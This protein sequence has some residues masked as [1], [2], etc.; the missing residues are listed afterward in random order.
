M[1]TRVL[2]TRDTSKVLILVF[3]LL[4]AGTG[5]TFILD[6]SLQPESRSAPDANSSH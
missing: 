3:A 1:P 5:A 4:A 2:N 6:L